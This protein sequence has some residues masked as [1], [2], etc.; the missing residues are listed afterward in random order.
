MK[1]P[2]ISRQI[3][4]LMSVLL[5][6][7]ALVVAKTSL[8][9]TTL[10]A[11]SNAFYQLKQKDNDL[12]LALLHVRN[13][14]VLH[15]DD[16]RYLN[17]DINVLFAS[18]QL[19]LVDED[20]KIVI[21]LT[22]LQRRLQDKENLI[23]QFKSDYSIL[24]N[25]INFLPQQLE[26]LIDEETPHN[27][28]QLLTLQRLF[29]HQFMSN[30]SD[31]ALFSFLQPLRTEH[32]GD[33]KWQ[34]ILMHI[35]H[36]INKQLNVNILLETIKEHPAIGHIN[37]LHD[38]LVN[39]LEDQL[40][41]QQWAI[42]ATYAM[43]ILLLMFSFW[44]L[45]QYRIV[46]RQMA[47]LN[48]DLADKITVAT[49]DI[50][51]EKQ[52]VEEASQAKSQ[53]L[54]RMSHELRTP[55]NA[56]IGFSQLQ[57][58]LANDNT[59][60]QQKENTEQVLNAGR[61][62]LGLINDML[63]V[64]NLDQDSINIDIEDCELDQV[65][66]QSVALVDK[67]AQASN[68]GIDVGEISQWVSADFLRLKQV[69]INLLTNAIKYNKAHGTITIT[70]KEVDDEQVQIAVE[71][72]GWGIEAV[73]QEKI[74]DPFTRLTYA[75]HNEI[76]GTGIGL[77]LTKFLVLQMNGTIGLHSQKNIGSTFWVTLP[78]AKQTSLPSAI[79]VS[80]TNDT[81]SHHFCVLY[82]EDNQASIQL[83]QQ[84]FDNKYPTITLLTTDT[85]EKGIIVAKG[86]R[87]DIIFIDINLPLM[88][89]IEAVANLKCLPELKSTYMVA[90]SADAQP[91]QIEKA[92]IAGFDDYLTKPVDL[93][94]LSGLLNE[95]ERQQL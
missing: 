71:D 27:K 19:L 92:R 87:P 83:L 77:A 15:Y 69:V 33:E 78:K 17:R 23:E 90:L 47:S 44:A 50:R 25:A 45:F 5:L 7:S 46:N 48:D 36:A 59:T 35:E 39:R 42:Y 91:K 88:S 29:F 52:K 94:K 81:L 58:M 8:P 28:Q 89:G 65:I 63:D 18:I 67:Q 76:Q 55:L 79:S 60:E 93:V 75:E 3:L 31:T 49:K 85:A 84:L 62:L 57:Q 64:A 22:S 82:I 41:Q 73:D 20:P 14:M 12:E 6:L 40:Q 80:E 61:H 9:L 72:T 24:K 38:V 11:A 54:T 13:G 26:Q 16:L 56:I 1:S 4:A 2:K 30:E 10:S 95:L 34:N 86:K 53:F 43:A 68:I 51:D 74:F 37:E 66:K 21:N 32:A 70:V